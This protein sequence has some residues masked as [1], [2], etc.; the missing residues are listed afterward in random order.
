MNLLVCSSALDE[1]LAY[2][3]VKLLFDK[4]DALVAAH[5]KRGTLPCPADLGASRA[6]FHAGAV[7]YYKEHGWK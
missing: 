1:Q 3:I 5:R 4:K 2:D 6:T 7:R